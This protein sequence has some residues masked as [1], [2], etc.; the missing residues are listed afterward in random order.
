MIASL[1]K[2]SIKQYDVA[3]RRWVS[4]CR[5]NNIDIYEASTPMVIYFLTELF[6]LGLQYGSL[7][8]HRSALS[9]ILGSR[10]GSDD[11]I[12]RLFKGF[13]RLRP[14]APKYDITWDPAVVLEF[15]A[16]WYPNNNLNL[17]YLTKKVVTLLM[18]VTAHRV[19]TIGKINLDNITIN[20][21]H[22]LISIKIHDLIKTSRPGSAQPYL[23]IPF[24]KDR[25]EICPAKTLVTYI[26]RT[27]PLRNNE[28]VLFISF[29]KP[30][31]SVSTN[32]ISRWI[33]DTLSVSGVDTSIFSAHSVRHAATSAAYRKGINID[34]IR[35]TA[36]WNGNSR[37]FARFY[38]RDIQCNQSNQFALS[39][40]N[41]EAD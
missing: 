31:K 27:K 35:N 6:Q 40:L 26:D 30:H 36:G 1:S 8:S 4:F 37:V 29:K 39:I 10:V 28:K 14:P 38:H 12:T 15:L 18:L 41:T 5:K 9:L 19:Q 24:Y 32:T 20:N 22:Q 2:N 33:K 11:R 16:N 23:N 17:E 34:T 13:Y 7:N 3:I 21:N 25:P